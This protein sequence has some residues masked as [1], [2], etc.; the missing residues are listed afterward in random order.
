MDPDAV[1]ARLDLAREAAR[2]AGDAAL[3]YFRGGQ[4]IAHEDK[5]DG[6]PVTEADRRAEQIVRDAIGSAFP[7]DGIIGEEFGERPGSSGFRWHIDPIDGTKTFIRGV[8]LWGTLIGVELGEEVVA[9]V[10]VY[11]AL[12]ESI[13]ASRGG[14][15][16]H[17]RTGEAARPARVSARSSLPEAC[18]CLTSAPGFRRRGAWDAYSGLCREFGLVRG[19]GDCFGWLLVATGRCEAMVETHVKSWDLA[20]FSVIIEEAGGRVTDWQG[21]CTIRA[22]D[23]VATGGPL[24]ESVIRI[25]RG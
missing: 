12:G 4:G 5:A 6:T 16:W 2:R 8:P 9:G 17:E 20:P 3:A 15:A 21:R 24:H 1:N 23:A 14:G 25:L 10:A 7:G 13:Y 22:G 19:W 11:P 18:L